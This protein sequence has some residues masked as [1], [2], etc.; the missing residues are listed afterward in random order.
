[1]CR[2]INTIRTLLVSPDSF[3]LIPQPPWLK[4]LHPHLLSV[5]VEDDGGTTV[6]VRIL[7]SLTC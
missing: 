3:P 5:M 1:M 2:D 4:I 6:N 7:A